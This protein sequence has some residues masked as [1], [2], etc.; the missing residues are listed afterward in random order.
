[1]PG[2]EQHF[3]ET[4]RTP[5]EATLITCSNGLKRG[6]CSEKC[7]PGL[8]EY[9]LHSTDLRPMDVDGRFL[10]ERGGFVSVSAREAVDRAAYLASLP[11]PAPHPPP[12]EDRAPVRTDPIPS[13]EL[14]AV[15]EAAYVA[16]EEWE[17]KVREAQGG[18]VPPPP[19][20]AKKRPRGS[21]AYRS[22]R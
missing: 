8:P 17:R 18:P 22:L 1:M 20:W 21:S 10:D 7:P 16:Y 15:Q 12:L 2:E 4:P 14:E 13:S 19:S 11:P 5:H 9:H 6:P 3:F